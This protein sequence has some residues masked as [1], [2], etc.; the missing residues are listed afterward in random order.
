MAMSAPLRSAP[1]D[2]SKIDPKLKNPLGKLRGIIRRY[3]ALEGLLAAALFLALWFWLAMLIDYGVFKLFAFDW[4][5]DALGRVSLWFWA[6][7]TGALVALSLFASRALQR[8]GPG[9]RSRKTLPKI[10]GDRLITAVQRSDLKWAGKYGYS[11]QMIAKT[12]DDVRGKIDQVPVG[13]VFN[14][15]RLLLQAGLFLTL[16][17]GMLV[18]SGVAVCAITKTPPKQFVH[19]FRDVSTIL[20]E[21]DLLMQNTPW[22]RRAY[23]ELVNFP[24]EGDLRVGRDAP[25]PR[26]RVAA[27]KWVVADSNAR[28][29]WR[30][31]TWADMQK[32]TGDAAN[33]AIAIGSRCPFRREL[34]AIPVRAR[35]RSRPV[36][37]DRCG[38]RARPARKMGR[39]SR[40]AGFPRQRRRQSCSPRSSRATL[41]RSRQH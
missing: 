37:A 1:P 6:S 7:R 20:A 9:P 27:F 32:I 41:T 29:G 21:R 2:P 34:W 36:A 8:F 19:E 31:M 5:L 39:R 4:A 13:K 10:L 38:R 23:L 11:E 33:T 3:V 26:I 12:I 16:T 35:I 17:F 24:A 15:K 22:P 14:W 40:R 25:S 30:P 18:L 28:V